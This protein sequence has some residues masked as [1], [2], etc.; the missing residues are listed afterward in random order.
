MHVIMH[1]H[2]VLLMELVPYAYLFLMRLLTNGAGYQPMSVN[3]EVR[4]YMASVQ[5]I[6]CFIVCLSKNK[7]YNKKLYYT[8][9]GS[10]ALMVKE[11]AL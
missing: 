1:E 10:C 4:V 9:L 2:G 5:R 8:Q 3:T 7:K 11:A 6:H